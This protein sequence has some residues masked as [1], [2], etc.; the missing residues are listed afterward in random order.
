MPDTYGAVRI[1]SRTTVKAAHR[2]GVDVHVWTV[3]DH[4]QMEALLAL[5]VDGLMTDRPDILA[6]VLAKDVTDHQEH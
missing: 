1:V 4:A 2:L 3:D 6:D 5:G